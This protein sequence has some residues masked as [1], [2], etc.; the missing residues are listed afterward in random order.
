MSVGTG[1]EQNTAYS[2]LHEGRQVTDW[3]RMEHADVRPVAR[4]QSEHELVEI[5]GH[6]A[7]HDPPV[8]LRGAGHS[9]GGQ[10]FCMDALMVDTSRLDR[11]LELDEESRTVRVQCGADWGVLTAA[12]EPLGLC[13]TTKQE[14]DLFTIGG[15]VARN[16]HGKSFDYGPLIE[17]ID[18]FRLLTAEG[19]IIRVSRNE[20][21]E[22][23][24]AVV[25]GYGLLGVVV[26]VTLCLV[27][28]RIVT[29]G[30]ITADA[31]GPLVSKYVEEIRS[32]R[33]RLPLC[34]GFLNA[35]CSHGFYLSY[36]YAPD[37]LKLP[38]DALKR[39]ELKPGLV[40]FSTR[41]Q[42]SSRLSR[43]ATIKILQSE[44]GGSETTLRSRR[45]LLW[46]DAPAAFKEMLVP[47]YFLPTDRF[48]EF[49][50]RAGEIFR[51]H[52]DS[53]K[54]LT[55]HFRFVPAND[56]SLLSFAP[57]DAI[58]MI[59]C[60]L[61]N[62]DSPS[63]KEQFASSNQLLVEAALDLGGRYYLTFDSLPTLEQLRRGYPR[64]DEL[65]ALKRQHD[66]SALFSSRF[67]Q[68]IRGELR[69]LE[70]AGVD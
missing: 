2:L 43:R 67:Y 13:V 40:N 38:L 55:N 39:G 14:F 12:L 8:T 68:R 17:A 11:I 6:A 37:D 24:P 48:A 31:S 35:E 53:L 58:C 22:L 5:I 1:I 20:N 51:K 61:A 19:R 64:W 42:R 27:E 47:K 63:W 30:P 46:D 69:R 50:D 18:S 16:V 49:C 33:N 65:V 28:D 32:G 59:P 60:Y 45:R 34:Y 7:R 44:S 54:V 25:G 36:E 23:L 62:K 57:Q 21:A 70:E 66:P 41:L 56:E 4:P 9:A 10:S 3:G 29:K 26:D 52:G 15:S